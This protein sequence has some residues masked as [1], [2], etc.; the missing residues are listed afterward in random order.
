MATSYLKAQT[1]NTPTHFIAFWV[2]RARLGA[3]R[4]RPEIDQMTRR[5][6]GLPSAIAGDWHGFPLRVFAPQRFAR[7]IPSATPI[8]FASHPLHVTNN[9]LPTFVDMNVLDGDLL[10]ALSRGGG[11]MLRAKSR[12]CERVCSL[13]SHFLCGLRMFARQS[14]PGDSIPSPRCEKRAVALQASP[15]VRPSEKRPQA[16]LR[17]RIAFRESDPPEDCVRAKWSSCPALVLFQHRSSSHQ[18]I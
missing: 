2:Q 8:S 17:Q 12:V 15:L 4:R 14:S 5:D 10:L 11:S 18:C 6:G 13:G 1:L 7:C 9:C 3:A 16:G